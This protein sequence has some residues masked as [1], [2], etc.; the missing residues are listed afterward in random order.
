MDHE[1]KIAIAI[2][3]VGALLADVVARLVASHLKK[4]RP[5]FTP[6]GYLRTSEQAQKEISEQDVF[7]VKARKFQFVLKWAE[8]LRTA[9]LVATVA[10]RLLQI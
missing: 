8:Y 5:G 2:T 9:M 10:I 1:L 4:I 7:V 6:A 3:A